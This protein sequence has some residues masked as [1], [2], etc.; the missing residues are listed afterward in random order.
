MPVDIEGM[1]RIR[2]I[3]PHMEDLSLLKANVQIADA[4]GWCRGIMESLPL[5]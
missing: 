2:L 4:I 1:N 5:T 3:S